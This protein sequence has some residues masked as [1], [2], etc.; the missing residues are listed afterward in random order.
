MSSDRRAKRKCAA[1]FIKH[2]SNC[3]VEKWPDVVKHATQIWEDNSEQVAADY[4]RELFIF[5][6]IDLAL[7]SSVGYYRLLEKRFATYKTPVNLSFVSYQE[8]KTEAGVFV[9]R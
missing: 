6:G 7:Y 2:S 9:R 5:V 1:R 4:T 8:K 3:C